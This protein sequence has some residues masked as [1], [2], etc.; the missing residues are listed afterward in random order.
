MSIVQAF[1]RLF[2]DRRPVM[3]TDYATEIFKLES[4]LADLNA[5]LGDPD[6]DGDPVELAN[7]KVAVTEALRAARVRQQAAQGQEYTAKL[8]AR[9]EKFHR[10]L[11]EPLEWLRANLPR[12]R[13]ELV[14]L[15]EMELRLEEE[16]SGR[17]WT[18]LTAGLPYGGAARLQ[19]AIAREVG[20]SD[21]SECYTPPAL[22]KV[23]DAARPLVAKHKAEKEA[24][25]A[26]RQAE[27]DAAVAAFE[28]GEGPDPRI[29]TYRV[30]AGR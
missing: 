15:E 11:S 1:Q 4:E 7:R 6:H 3:V 25:R 23:I 10:D 22:Q 29:I 17:S 26:A 12:L 28:R 9:R 18:E 13:Y 21:W 20:S 2:T 24:Q 5:V 19:A 8:Q 14:R 27:F 16:G 30:R